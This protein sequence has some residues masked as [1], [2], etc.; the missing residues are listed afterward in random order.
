MKENPSANAELIGYADE[1]GDPTYNK[2]LSEKRAAKVKEILVASGISG[3]R[4]TVT[5][6]GE[7]TSVEKGSAPARQ[8][9]RRVTF[10]LK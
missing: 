9:V 7:D 2:N 6:N 10:K 4:L 3:N 5:G 1:I 8:L